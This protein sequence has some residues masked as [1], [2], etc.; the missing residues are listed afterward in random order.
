MNDFQSKNQ[1]IHHVRKADHK[2]FIARVVDFVHGELNALHLA[3][4]GVLGP[5]G[6]PLFQPLYTAVGLIL[7][8]R[9]HHTTHLFQR[10][11]AFRKS[12]GVSVRHGCFVKIN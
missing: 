6:H 1:S 2:R 4:T 5:G 11:I 7:L 10:R 12:T 9:F 8:H 3:P